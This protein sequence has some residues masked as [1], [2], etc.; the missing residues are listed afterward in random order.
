M[1]STHSGGWGCAGPRGKLLCP[2]EIHTA[3]VVRSGTRI[4]EGRRVS[5]G[6]SGRPMTG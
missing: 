2:L 3:L 5:W 1:A 4:D 6:F